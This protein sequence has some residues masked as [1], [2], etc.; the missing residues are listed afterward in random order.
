MAAKITGAAARRGEQSIEVRGA[1]LNGAVDVAPFYDA[2]GSYRRPLD[3][4]VSRAKPM[5]RIEADL[6][7]DT[8]QAPTAGDFFT[9]NI[10]ARS[11]DGKTLGE[12][13]LSSDGKVNTYPFDAGPDEPTPLF[14]TDT[15]F[16]RWHRVAIQLDDVNRKTT[17]FMDGQPLGLPTDFD[18]DTGNVLA[19]AAMVV[20]ARKDGGETGTDGSLRSNYTARFDNFKVSVGRDANDKS[21]DDDGKD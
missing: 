19:R 14:S 16:N 10:A 3:Y 18:A 20:Y 17:Y 8:N 21:A 7:L 12:L 6:L 4:T 9:L 2:V 1:A 5:V 15:T 13:G 11:G